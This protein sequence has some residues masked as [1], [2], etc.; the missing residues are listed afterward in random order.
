MRVIAGELAVDV[1]AL[2]H[3]VLKP[4]EPGTVLHVARGARD[5]Q[6][7]VGLQ[8]RELH[9]A[10]VKSRGGQFFAIQNDFRHGWSDELDERAIA[11]PAAPEV[12]SR[13]GPEC[14]VTG[15]E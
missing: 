15:R 5:G 4:V 13:L 3:R 6:R 11:R 8:V 1:D 9:A 2:V 12:D 7:V 10:T 14:F